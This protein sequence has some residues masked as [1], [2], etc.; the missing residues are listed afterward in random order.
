MFITL[1]ARTKILN[2][3]I[4]L[5]YKKLLFLITV[6]KNF[7]FGGFTVVQKLT[8]LSWYEQY[9]LK[10]QVSTR[11]TDRFLIKNYKGSS[12]CI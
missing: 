9:L 8:M 1:S 2:W 6:K 7:S 12:M 3:K 4:P 5:D 10:K 11:I